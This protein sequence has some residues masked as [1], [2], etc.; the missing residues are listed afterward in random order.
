MVNREIGM[1]KVLLLLTTLIM[2]SCYTPTVNQVELYGTVESVLY[3]NK[4]YHTKVWCADRGRYY[5]I[6]GDK[7]YQPGTVVRIK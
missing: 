3:Y 4:H 5:E 7:L 6:V 1:K 2:V